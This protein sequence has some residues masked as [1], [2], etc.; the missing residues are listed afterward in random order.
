MEMSNL[1]RP[2]THYAWMLLDG[3]INI[4]PIIRALTDISIR[5]VSPKRF[6]VEAAQKVCAC[7]KKTNSLDKMDIASARRSFIQIEQFPI[8]IQITEFQRV[9]LVIA[10][11]LTVHTHSHTMFCT[12]IPWTLWFLRCRREN[13]DKQHRYWYRLSSLL[14]IGIVNGSSP[15]V[16]FPYCGCTYGFSSCMCVC[17]CD[18]THSTDRQKH[19]THCSAVYC[20]CC[21]CWWWCCCC[22][23]NHI[24]CADMLYFITFFLSCFHSFR[25][26]RSDELFLRSF[27]LTSFYLLLAFFDTHTHTPPRVL[28]EL[29]HS[30]ASTSTTKGKLVDGARF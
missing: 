22:C 10:A 11:I 20:C 5:F 2:S 3:P 24:S 4:V 13:G 14:C 17:V 8:F 7:T 1:N 9:F 16:D 25:S 23:H 6:S 27:F 15:A 18:Y 28:C 12:S 21:C 29:I 19:C 26:F 30:I